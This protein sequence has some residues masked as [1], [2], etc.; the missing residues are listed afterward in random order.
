MQDM[1]QFGDIMSIRSESNMTEILKNFSSDYVL[2]IM[3][4]EIDN[5]KNLPMDISRTINNIVPAIEQEFLRL[6]E[7]YPYDKENLQQTRIEIYNN[8]ILTIANQY[9]LNI[10][11]PEDGDLFNITNALYQF[12]VS[13][14]NNTIV[15]FFTSFIINN[16][17]S[18]H[19]A[20]NIPKKKDNKPT[21]SYSYKNPN[22]M[23]VLNSMNTVMAYVT[24]M[25]ITLDQFM[26]SHIEVYKV[27][28]D[29]VTENDSFVREFI[30]P[31][32][33]DYQ[34]SPVLIAYIKMN[35]HNHELA[36]QPTIES[37]L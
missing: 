29:F 27:L 35:V 10:V 26:S 25:D 34:F 7:D 17:D 37:Y 20:I 4:Q 2:S 11:L 36:Y 33:I 22:T 21:A 28:R 31:K 12:F 30:Y 13:D 3:C 8:I 15:S 24:G 16:I 19:D 23:D 9:K 14:L 1:N 32:L 5:F 18:L 6:S